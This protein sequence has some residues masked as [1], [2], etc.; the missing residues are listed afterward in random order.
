MTRSFSSST[1]LWSSCRDV[2]AILE[3][4]RLA[5]SRTAA[6]PKRAI[7]SLCGRSQRIPVVRVIWRHESDRVREIV[8]DVRKQSIMK[9]HVNRFAHVGIAGTMQGQ[10]DP[11]L[12][13]MGVE[14]GRSLESTNVELIRKLKGNFGLVWDRSGHGGVHKSC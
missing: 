3:F 13:E 14:A 1:I 12:I 5:P 8:Q 2:G 6:R 4:A 10:R 9:V 7:K 11:G